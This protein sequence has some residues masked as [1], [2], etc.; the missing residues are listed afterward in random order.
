MAEPWKIAGNEELKLTQSQIDRA[1]SRSAKMRSLMKNLPNAETSDGKSVK[2]VREGNE[3][4]LNDIHRL[5]TRVL[6]ERD[7]KNLPELV[8]RA[9]L[10]K[11][12]E[13]TKPGQGSPFKQKI[14]RFDYYKLVL[15]GKTTYLNIGHVVE[16]DGRSYNVLYA[17]NDHIK[18]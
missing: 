6:R 14:K 3:H 8:G 7:L 18:R 17:V 10:V 4:V 1:V 15:R 12:S 9:E 5:N 16:Q 2:F 11:S 13:N